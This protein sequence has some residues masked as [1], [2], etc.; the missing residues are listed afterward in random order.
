VAGNRQLAAGANQ[1][2]DKNDVEL[3]RPM[4]ILYWALEVELIPSQ[5]P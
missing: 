4:N 3:G 2:G 5:C 1:N